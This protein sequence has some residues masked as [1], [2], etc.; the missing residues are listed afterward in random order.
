MALQSRL[1]LVRQRVRTAP[2][3][4]VGW[5]LL[6]LLWLAFYAVWIAPLIEP[7]GEF[8]WGHYRKRDLY[9]GVPL[10]LAAV[11]MTLVMTRPAARRRA[12]SVRLVAA[13]P[14]TL[15]AVVV[16]DVAY[17]L[18]LP[19]VFWYGE[20]PVPRN[21]N[22]PDAELGWVRQ[23]NLRWVGPNPDGTERVAYRTDEH[24]FRNPPGLKRADIVFIGDSY[25]EATGVQE[26]ETFA[27]RA[28]SATGLTVANLGRSGYSPPQELI[29]LKK[30]GLSYRPRVV[31]WQLFEF[32]DLNDAQ[33][34]AA[35]RDARGQLPDP[36][37]AKR[38]AAGSLL[39][40]FVEK[41]ARPSGAYQLR[42]ANGT[43]RPQGLD[44]RYR[45]DGPERYVEGF[46][47][48]K[49]AIAEGY[50]L[51][52]SRDIDLLVLMVPTPVRFLADQLVFADPGER[53]AFL[54]DGRVSHPE[55]FVTQLGAYC[56]KLGCPVL[57]LYP[58]LRAQAGQQPLTFINDG[59]LN[60]A[61][62]E[63]VAGEIARWL[64]SR[65]IGEHETE[66]GT[67]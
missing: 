44:W 57:D 27:A 33:D 56:R 11:G 20:R 32:N 37:L 14:T 52:R 43:V 66:N 54:P 10:A 41:T 19:P 25:T 48:T 35:W 17:S 50:R 46:E 28:G 18:V 51:C 22:Q 55:D 9:V 24:G 34:Y 53:E 47:E 1:A 21:E 59:H 67:H 23:P 5:A 30:H 3:G 63:V 8:G 65:G 13:V 38:Y 31:V 15:A 2:S 64:R 12:L 42:L 61:G 49:R 36:P 4:M 45:P 58:A 26:V 39:T 40:S 16:F 6:V 62:N 29:I 7:R 60:A